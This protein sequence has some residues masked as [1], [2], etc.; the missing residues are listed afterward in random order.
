[1]A[2]INLALLF[3]KNVSA[4]ITTSLQLDYPIRL[5]ISNRWW[6]WMVEQQNMWMQFT[7]FTWRGRQ[8]KIKQMKNEKCD[9]RRNDKLTWR[10]SITQKCLLLTQSPNGCGGV[11][12]FHIIILYFFHC[13]CR[14]MD[15]RM[16]RVLYSKDQNYATQTWILHL[17]LSLKIQ[18]SHF[19]GT[20]ILHICISFYHNNE[21]HAD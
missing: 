20:Y 21:S 2:L 12:H 7:G 5:V 1:M 14:E 4:S 17:V 18:V 6:P 16:F 8:K 13:Q 10:V 3:H 9:M 19:K 15:W 11:P